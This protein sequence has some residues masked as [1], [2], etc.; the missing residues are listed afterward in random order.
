MQMK[1]EL[2]PYHINTIFMP[3]LLE[4]I[5]NFYLVDTH[6]WFSKPNILYSAVNYT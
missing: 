4:S 3:I 6:V 2:K 1:F 5:F